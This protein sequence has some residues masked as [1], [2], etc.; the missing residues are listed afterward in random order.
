MGIKEVKYFRPFAQTLLSKE[1]M[2]LVTYL[3]V[4][5]YLISNMVT[6]LEYLGYIVKITGLIITL[7]EAEFLSVFVSCVQFLATV[8]SLLA[9]L[10]GH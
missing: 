4:I 3:K 1:K 10:F 8:S 7:Q 5:N 2:Y 9:F 6:F